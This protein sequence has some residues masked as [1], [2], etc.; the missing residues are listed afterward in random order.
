MTS[1]STLKYLCYLLY[2]AKV[3]KWLPS[4]KCCED[5]RECFPKEMSGHWDQNSDWSGSSA[6]WSPNGSVLRRLLFCSS[7]TLLCKQRNHMK[8][9]LDKPSGMCSLS[10][11]STSVW[12]LNHPLEFTCL[13]SPK[14]G[15]FPCQEMLECFFLSQFSSM[16]L[17]SLH[18]CVL[19]TFL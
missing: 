19:I 12:L 4:W 14:C 17:D 5:I 2:W 9:C 7:N 1:V 13:V 18:C 15:L 11:P 10:K 3:L 8:L 6:T 16:R